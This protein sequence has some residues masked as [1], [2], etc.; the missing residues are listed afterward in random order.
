MKEIKDY[1]HHYIGQ[2]VS[3]DHNGIIEYAKL[4][5]VSQ[6]EIERDRYVSVIDVDIDHF[7]EWYIEETILCLR[8]LSDMTE[9]YKDMLIDDYNLG[10]YELANHMYT[11]SAFKKLLDDGFDVFELIPAG[12]AIDKTTLPSENS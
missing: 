3:R 1:I 12:L 2:K 8:P 4:V 7:H 11:P 9:E 6:S 10:E 5:G